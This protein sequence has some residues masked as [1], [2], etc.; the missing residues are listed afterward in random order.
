MFSM[1]N[2]LYQGDQPA[3]TAVYK[4][5]LSTALEHL[6]PGNAEAS[7]FVL[8]LCHLVG[9]AQRT[10]WYERGFRW[11]DSVTP[12][13]GVLTSDLSL[14][15]LQ[16]TPIHLADRLCLLTGLMRVQPLPVSVFEVLVTLTDPVR[17][18]ATVTAT[19]PDDV[20]VECT[21]RKDLFMDWLASHCSHGDVNMY[22]SRQVCVRFHHCGSWSSAVATVFV[23]V[24]C[25]SWTKCSSRL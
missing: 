1:F 23:F 10:T 21:W 17:I 9:L 3:V 14:P 13:L 6:V 24:L 16:Q 19:D 11:V 12:V 20:R 22:H 4:D 18:R 8:P 15:P 5:M 2:S 7:R 25:R